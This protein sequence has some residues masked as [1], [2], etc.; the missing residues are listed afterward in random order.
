MPASLLP[1][2]VGCI[3]LVGIWNASR[4]NHFSSTAPR[5]AT[6]NA[7]RLAR[8][9][10]IVGAFL[11]LPPATSTGIDGGTVIAV[12][13]VLPRAQHGQER[14]LRDL[15]AADLPHALLAFL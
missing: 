2:R 8:T 9:G 7:S 5:I 6:P 11:R 10:P 4:Q 14:L 13:S 3:E 15:D 12:M 1:I